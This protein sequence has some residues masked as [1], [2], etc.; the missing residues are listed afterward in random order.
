MRGQKIVS[1]QSDTHVSAPVVPARKLR[2]LLIVMV[3]MT[4]WRWPGPGLASLTRDWHQL[5]QAGTGHCE[6]GLTRGFSL[7]HQPSEN[8]S[9]RQGREAIHP[10]IRKKGNMK[11]CREY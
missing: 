11:L 1:G 9:P 5:G 10:V 7:S 2:A 8:L 6:R 4:A 3:V